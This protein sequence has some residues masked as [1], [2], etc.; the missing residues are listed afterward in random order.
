M[1]D[2]DAE[3]VKE[4]TFLKV[5]E[6]MANPPVLDAQLRFPLLK[7]S[8]GRKVL[9]VKPMNSWDKGRALRHIVGVL[10]EES[11][12]DDLFC[13]YIGDDRT[14]EDAFAVVDSSWISRAE[15][16][17]GAID[18]IGV[19]VSTVAK[20]TCARHSLRDPSEVQKFLARLAD[21]GER[22]GSAWSAASASS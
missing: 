21:F 4:A 3:R 16:A 17:E 13:V 7:V 14:D 22:D 8:S 19:V 12:Y 11:G 9:E 18:G 10:Q 15:D 2:A 5:A 1:C 20:A 6:L